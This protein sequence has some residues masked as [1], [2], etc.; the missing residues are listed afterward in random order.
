VTTLDLKVLEQLR[1]LRL[2]AVDE[3]RSLVDR[4][5]AETARQ[6]LMNE[7]LA[8]ELGETSQGE[9]QAP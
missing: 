9:Q 5:R 6:R 7:A 8:R 3:G 4:L 2:I 1:E